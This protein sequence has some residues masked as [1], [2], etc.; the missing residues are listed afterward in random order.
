[1]FFIVLPL[2]QLA[3][4]TASSF[5]GPSGS[6]TVQGNYLVDR[7]SGGGW[8]SGGFAPKYVQLELPTTYNI[9]NV[10]L[11]VSQSPNGVTRDELSTGA[12]TSSLQVVRTLNS[13]T[14]AGQWINITFN[15]Q[16]SGIRFLRVT[17]T[18]SPSWVAWH[19]FIVYG[20]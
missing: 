5:Y 10:L 12:T 2:S 7:L 9:S 17:T 1:M 6:P 14:S 16:L 3:S 15:P 4:V 13:Y 19:K 18:S 20:F 11:K 8:N